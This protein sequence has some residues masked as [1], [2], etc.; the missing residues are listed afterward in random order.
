MKP[1]AKQRQKL[2][3]VFYY[4]WKNCKIQGKLGYVTMLNVW[5]KRQ[6]ILTATCRSLKDYFS[7][8]GPIFQ[9]EISRNNLYF[10]LSIL[11][12]GISFTFLLVYS[13]NKR[14]LLWKKTTRSSFL[15]QTCYCIC[16]QTKPMHKLSTLTVIS[17]DGTVLRKNKEFNH[18]S[19]SA[20]VVN[21]FD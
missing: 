10:L 21:V 6:V 8:S 11:K 17:L 5:T 12:F 2:T 7:P 20:D 3:T 1:E 18:I 19:F 9:N 16:S 14:L 4:R 13:V 15:R